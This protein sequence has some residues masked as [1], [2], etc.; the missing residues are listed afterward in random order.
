MRAE[1]YEIQLHPAN[2]LVVRNVP[3]VTAEGT[4]AYGTLFVPVTQVSENGVGVPP[5]HQAYFGGSFPHKRAG[6]PLT[7][8]GQNVAG[9]HMLGGGLEAQFHL[10]F[11]SD[12]VDA[13]GRYSDYHAL[14]TEYVAMMWRYAK[15]VDP[16]ATPLTHRVDD[17]DDEPSV[18]SYRDTASTRAEIVPITAKLEDHKIAIIGLGGTGSYVLDFVSKTPVN[19]IRLY[20][21]DRFSQHNAFRTPGAARKED[22]FAQPPVAKVEYLQRLYSALHLNIVAVPRFLDDIPAEFASIDFVFLCIDNPAAKRPIV[23]GLLK[24]DKPFIDVGL[25]VISEAGTLGGV[26]RT[27]FSAPG[28]RNHR[29]SIPTADVDDDYR[30]NIQIAELNGLNAAMAVIRWKKHLGFYRAANPEYSSLYTVDF[31]AIGNADRDES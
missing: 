28:H 16:T 14:V 4:V 6:V 5:N 29:N 23:A 2:Q 1:G 30:T 12:K 31:N 21:G 20:D 7:V 18:F 9:Q 13:S 10:S 27:T 25:G 8:L 26:L 15:R 11:K 17:Y 24:L 3:Y 22:V 19:E